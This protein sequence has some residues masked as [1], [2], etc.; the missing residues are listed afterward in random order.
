MRGGGKMVI[1]GEIVIRESRLSS[2]RG[3]MVSSDIDGY[4][5][6]VASD[7]GLCHELNYSDI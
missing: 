5:F 4:H 1:E 2:R 6:M 3:G 7:E